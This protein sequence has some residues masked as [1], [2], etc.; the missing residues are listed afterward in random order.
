MTVWETTNDLVVGDLSEPVAGITGRV[1]L[2]MHLP[3]V[4]HMPHIF[5][6]SNPVSAG[7]SANGTFPELESAMFCLS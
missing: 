2:T 1:P 3:G 5:N 7:C 6:K 4:Q